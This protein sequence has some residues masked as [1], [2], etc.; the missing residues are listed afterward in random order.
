MNLHDYFPVLLDLAL[1]GTTVLLL[2]L[3]VTR[4][5]RRASAAGRHAV[6]L[7]AFGALLLLPATRLSLFQQEAENPADERAAFVIQVPAGPVPEWVVGPG[8]EKLAGASSIWP[9]WQ[10][11]VAGVW[12]GGAGMLLALRGLAGVRLWHLR[13][14]GGLVADSR[15]P[16]CCVRLAREAGIARRV[17]LLVAGNCR[18]AM[19]WGTWRPVV[20]LPAGAMEW[21]DERLALVLRHELAHVKRGDFLTRLL[22]HLAC[23]IYWPNPLVWFAARRARLA[24]EQAC[25]DLVL[26]AGV[27]PDA[28]ALELVAAARELNGSR[29]GAAVA[30]AEPSTL[31]RRVLGILGEGFDRRALRRSTLLLA[32]AGVLLALVGCSTLA[33]R[34]QK[35]LADA[36]AI[37]ADAPQVSISARFVQIEAFARVGNL[38]D[39]WMSPAAQS[40]KSVVTTLNSDQA[41]NALRRLSGMAGVDILSTPTITVKA[42]QPAVISIGQELRYPARWARDPRGDGW[43]PAEFATQ[44]VGVEMNARAE[45]NDD[46]TVTLFVVP[47]VVELEGFVGNELPPP[48]E[49]Q[50]ARAKADGNVQGDD[51]TWEISGE[52]VGERAETVG[53]WLQPVF[54]VREMRSTIRLAPG[55]TV[56]LRGGSS[57]IDRPLA[58]AA[59]RNVPPDESADTAGLWVLV[60]A[61]LV[62]ATPAR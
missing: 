1:K 56:V 38:E 4:V 54:S 46:G 44:N 29:V 60:T 25:D 49:F 43:L 19:T 18:V 52:G 15:L 20:L 30:M 9:S 22:V 62:P 11:V 13:R 6:W 41:D 23:A 17:E 37:P 16:T 3:L 45:V 5:W 34:A 12:L 59:E 28:Y 53:E 27:P 21:T 50:V 2:A 35:P 31:E 33:V 36:T 32:V 7:A 55:Q 24:Q 47:K 51:Y 58:T 39:F 14:R 40:A 48:L 61:K 8:G 57:K 42:G 10:V 26:A